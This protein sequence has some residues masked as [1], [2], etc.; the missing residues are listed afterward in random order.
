MRTPVR[1]ARRR[2]DAVTTAI[3]AVRETDYQIDVE[4]YC[5]NEDCAGRE[6]HVRFKDYDNTLLQTIRTRGLRC[7]ACNGFLKLHWVRNGHDA[8]NSAAKSACALSRL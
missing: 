8:T 6:V 1:V 4:G 3:A 5:D 2:A 7:P